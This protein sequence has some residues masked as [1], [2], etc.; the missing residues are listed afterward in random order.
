M[1]VGVLIHHL[2]WWSSFLCRIVHFFLLLAARNENMGWL[3]QCRVGVISLEEVTPVLGHLQVLNNHC[4]RF[5]P[6]QLKGRDVPVSPSD[7]HVCCLV[8]LTAL[9]TDAACLEA[10]AKF[11][12]P[13]LV[14]RTLLCI[15]LQFVAFCLQLFI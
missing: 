13:G 9:S 5:R 12:S 15:P 11:I 1:Q 6:T 7:S 14:L 8:A 2:K 4:S 3:H 10:S